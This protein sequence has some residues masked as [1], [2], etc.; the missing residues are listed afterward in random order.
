MVPAT[1]CS[2]S[3]ERGAGLIATAAGVSV[4]LV[5]L[6]FCTQLLFNLYATSVVTAAAS[7]AVRIVARAG[8][9]PGAQEAARGGAETHARELLGRYADR[10]AFEWT[11]GPEEVALHVTA[12]NRNFLF[13][14][15]ALDAMQ[16]VDR[17]VRA[18]VECFREEDGSCRA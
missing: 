18:R 7:D 11:L 1:R 8:G 5:L 17:T 16:T 4:F 9:E 10:V 3:D 15:L 6:L 12:E 2:A 13:G 14:A